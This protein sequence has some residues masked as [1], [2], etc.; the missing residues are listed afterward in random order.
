[1]KKGT[2]IILAL[3]VVLAIW[4]FSS[5]NSLVSLNE[6]ADAQWAQVEAQYQRRLDLIPNLVNSVKGALTQEQT[7]FGDIAKARS[8]YTAATT[9]DQK[10]AAASQVES[11]LGR[12]IAIVENYPQLTST[13]AVR[14]LM[15]QLEGTENRV[16]VERN[17]FNDIVRDYNTTVKRFPG[18]ISA[19][20]FGFHDRSYFQ[21]A[22][23]AENA[24]TVNLTS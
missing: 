17:R 11:S 13:Q 7:V 24:P 23:G 1:M 14:D 6:R 12:L 8:Q 9:P 10:A 3:V 5:Y 21:A 18:N 4:A 20:L 22:T 16:S 2:L 19:G 15:T